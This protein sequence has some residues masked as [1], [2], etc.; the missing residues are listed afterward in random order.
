[1]KSKDRYLNSKK[2]KS[3]PFYKRWKIRLKRRVWWNF[4]GAWWQIDSFIRRKIGLHDPH[5][6][7]ADVDD[8]E[9]EIYYVLHENSLCKNKNISDE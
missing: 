4:Q 1:M 3:Y 8:V 2:F 7:I 9:G 5:N 6:D